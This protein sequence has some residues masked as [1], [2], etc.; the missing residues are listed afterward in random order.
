MAL[1]RSS[2][3]QS[4]AKHDDCLGQKKILTSMSFVYDKVTQLYTNLQI[5]LKN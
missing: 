2:E 4:R 1:K 3:D 5:I